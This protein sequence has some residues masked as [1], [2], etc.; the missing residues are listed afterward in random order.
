MWP[1]S[2]FQCLVLS[3]FFVHT[4]EKRFPARLKDLLTDMSLQAIYWFS[5]AQ[6]YFTKA[7]KTLGGPFKPVTHDKNKY[8]V[9]LHKQS[10]D[11]ILSIIAT[12]TTYKF[13]LLEC[14]PVCEEEEEQP[15]FKIDLKTNEYNYYV[16]GNRLNK[17]FFRY[18]LSCHLGFQ[19]QVNAFKVHLIDNEV[20]THEIPMTDKG[21]NILL[22]PDSY[23]L[24]NT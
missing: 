23:V 21:E 24:S 13:I 12:E 22:L 4:I 5:R 19:K 7:Y 10:D 9:T 17:D 2:F 20:K 1:A 11:N 16:A 14:T 18:F 6:I 3:T 15:T 8:V